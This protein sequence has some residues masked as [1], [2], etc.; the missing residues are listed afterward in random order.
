MVAG[1]AFNAAAGDPLGDRIQTM[2]NRI[3]RLLGN[4]KTMS[5]VIREVSDTLP[6]MLNEDEVY[7]LWEANQEAGQQLSNDDLIAQLKEQ[8]KTFYGGERGALAQLVDL[9]AELADRPGQAGV[10]GDEIG[11][12]PR[13]DAHQGGIKDTPG[14]DPVATGAVEDLGV[15]GA[16]EDY[17]L[18][19]IDPGQDLDPGRVPPPP[20]PPEPKDPYFDDPAFNEM[21]HERGSKFSRQIF[22]EELRKIAWDNPNKDPMELFRIFEKIPDDVS[23]EAFLAGKLRTIKDYAAEF[24]IWDQEALLGQAG[25]ERARAAHAAA[26]AEAAQARAAEFAAGDTAGRVR[27]FDTKGDVEL[28]ELGENQLGI[29]E[30]NIADFTPGD[31]EILGKLKGWVGTAA[32]GLS[33]PIA[34]VGKFLASW[35]A[36][37][38]V[39]APFFLALY[40]IIPQSTDKWLNLGAGLMGA[41]LGDPLGAVVAGAT[42]LITEFNHQA[43]RRE[44]N[45][46]SYYGWKFGFTRHGKDWYPS[47]TGPVTRYTAFGSDEVTFDTIYGTGLYFQKVA[48]VMRPFWSNLVGTKK[49]IRKDLALEDEEWGSWQ[50]HAMSD[51]LSDQYFL[52]AEEQKNLLAWMADPDNTELK[53]N[54]PAGDKFEVYEDKLEDYNLKT[55]GGSDGS[56]EANQ[57]EDTTLPAQESL[58]DLRWAMDYIQDFNFRQL[59]EGQRDITIGQIPTIQRVRRNSRWTSGP[60]WQNNKKY[61]YSTDTDTYTTEMQKGNYWNTNLNDTDLI[62]ETLAD[63]MKTLWV[64]QRDASMSHGFEYDPDQTNLY[65]DMDWRNHR[66]PV[67]EKSD[68]FD[69]F[70]MITRCAHEYAPITFEQWLEK[71]DYLFRVE[72]LGIWA[73][74]KEWTDRV[75]LDFE[76]LEGQNALDEVNI[77]F[78]YEHH[79]LEEEQSKAKFVFVSVKHDA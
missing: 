18:G 17:T 6:T 2:I 42:Y 9:D 44:Q 61:Q 16:G 72:E 28:M 21:M 68:D 62:E 53:I 66:C 56:N 10:P 30:A 59:P 60:G 57:F 74:L 11:L 78:I 70:K 67:M 33:I 31:Y 47:F 76:V 38:L 23:T 58:L 51:G 77:Y 50:F 64:T 41:M 5:E 3:D 65:Q 15:A 20:P 12:D 34:R 4:N 14:Q 43:E 49:F 37:Q 13:D 24:D 48:G 45:D 55:Y 75:E 69:Y 79:V 32:E 26:K 39:S 19:I 54:G 29:T 35:G 8:G 25:A 52:T 27:S 1:H 22:D 73:G 63:Q 40:Q 46:K 36:Q 7:E 71:R